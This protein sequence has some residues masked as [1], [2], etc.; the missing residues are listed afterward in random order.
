MQRA[1]KKQLSVLMSY[2]HIAASALLWTGNNASA[3]KNMEKSSGN[4]SD[5]EG[6]G[7]DNMEETKHSDLEVENDSGEGSI[8]ANDE[9]F[10][11]DEILAS[12]MKHGDRMVSYVLQKFD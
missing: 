7:D 10:L 4:E 1:K 3:S 6:E 11:A 8:S 5:A 9:P 2:D 12:V